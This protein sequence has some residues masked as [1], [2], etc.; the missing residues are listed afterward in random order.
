MVETYQCE[1]QT[2]L[3]DPDRLALFRTAVNVPAAEENKRWQEICNIDEIPEQAGIGAHLGR[4][5]IA[6][7]RFGKTVYALD[8]R[9][10]GQPRERAVTRHPR[11]CGGGT[12]GDLAALQ[13]T[14]SS[15]RRVSG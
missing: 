2:T 1:W 11:R 14:Y 6:L 3:N 9:G 4:K 8:D 12:G 10:A 7:F 13:A 15:A 5:P